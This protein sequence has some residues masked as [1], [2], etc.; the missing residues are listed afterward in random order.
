MKYTLK[1]YVRSPDEAIAS[2]G[3]RASLVAL[4]FKRHPFGSCSPTY[5]LEN[6]YM[7]TSQI[8]AYTLRA[9]LRAETL[10]IGV[11]FLGIVRNSSWDNTF[12]ILVMSVSTNIEVKKEYS[13]PYIF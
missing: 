9:C 4:L 2:R 7:Y 10:Q 6:L 13:L 3:L 1:Y 11:E 5:I 12:Y 8:Y